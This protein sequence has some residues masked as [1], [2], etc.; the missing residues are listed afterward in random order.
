MGELDDQAGQLFETFIQ[1]ATCKGTL[2]AFNILCRQLDL[3]PSDYSAFY[4]NLKSA[5]T[6][7]K[8][9][10]LWNK[11]DKR[12]SHK[13]YNKGNACIDTRVRPTLNSTGNIILVIFVWTYLSF[14]EIFAFCACL[15]LEFISC[16]WSVLL[17]GACDRYGGTSLCT[18]YF[19]L[20]QISDS[21]DQ[22]VSTSAHELLRQGSVVR[23]VPN[24]TKAW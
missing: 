4:H 10:P 16:S 18:G 21:I 14:F 9:E 20:S 1:A 19:L 6:S 12:A 17:S 23:N 13:E 2:Q 8:A 24:A 3:D 22:F 7:W 15:R 11:L 5:V